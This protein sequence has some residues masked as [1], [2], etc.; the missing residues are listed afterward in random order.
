MDQEADNLDKTAEAA[1]ETM[2]MVRD[3]VE[4][5]KEIAEKVGPID[6]PPRTRP[7]PSLTSA[8]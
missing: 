8:S 3:K 6:V 4:A 1:E 7:P 2:A 5:I